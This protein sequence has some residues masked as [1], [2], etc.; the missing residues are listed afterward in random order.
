[1]PENTPDTS[2]LVKRL[3]NDIGGTGGQE[4]VL[5]HE[6]AMLPWEK[7]THALLDILDFH[8][9]VNTEE[10]RC[11]VEELGSDIGAK[12][13]YY[14]KWLVGTVNLLRQ[15]RI[16][17]ADEIGMKTREVSLRMGVPV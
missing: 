12:L 6:H 16:L 17:T 8:K 14:E 11:S 1:M 5:M 3:I 13:S 4:P 15:K 2:L 10:K 7:R 9:L